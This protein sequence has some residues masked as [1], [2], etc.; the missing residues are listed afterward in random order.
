MTIA[1]RDEQWMKALGYLLTPVQHEGEEVRWEWSLT[2]RT[3]SILLPIGC[4]PEEAAEML[5]YQE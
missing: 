3:G 2:T 5:V 1:E 4:T